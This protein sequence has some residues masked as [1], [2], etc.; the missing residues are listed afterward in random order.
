MGSSDVRYRKHGEHK[1]T[2]RLFV[3]VSPE[4]Y[5]RVS[6]RAKLL[7]MSM[8]AYLI[9]LSEQYEAGAFTVH[10]DTATSPE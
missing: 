8:G 6:G 5:N 3:R 10:G 9:W 2:K 7:G 1:R 4:E